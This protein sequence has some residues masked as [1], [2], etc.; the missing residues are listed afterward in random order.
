LAVVTE[1]VNTSKGKVTGVVSTRL[2]LEALDTFKQVCNELGVESIGSTEEGLSAS[3]AFS[4]VAKDGKPFEAKFNDIK[5][6]TCFL[7]VGEDTTKDHQVVSF[8]VKR[9]LPA[10]A[11]L[12]QVSSVATGLDNFANFTLRVSD[13]KTAD[14]MK[15]FAGAI[16]SS[17][18]YAQ[19]AVKFGLDEKTVEEAGKALKSAAKLA[20]ILGSRYESAGSRSIAEAA[21]DFTANLKGKLVST[22]GNINSLGASQFNMN[23]PVKVDG[24]EVVLLAAAD[25]KLTQAQMKKFEK[26]PFLVVFSSYASPLTASADVVL[27]VMNWL[28][29]GGH[30]LN[31]DGHVLEAQASLKADENILSNS[32][33]FAKLASKL[34]VKTTPAW[35]SAFSAP[36]VVVI[37]K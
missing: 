35:E 19:V 29:Q 23:N 15:D 34:N 5:D 3:H 16:Q 9:S 8:F 12:V 18:G 20:V 14:F 6:A 11:K 24:A 22:K 13:D 4:A 1:K 2:S 7:T 28:E 21:A 10:G 33:A 37:S 32:D 26:A 17:T 36:S 25:E 27:P 30:F 31:F